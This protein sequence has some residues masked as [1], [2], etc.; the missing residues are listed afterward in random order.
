MNLLKQIFRSYISG[1]EKFYDFTGRAT[2]LEFWSFALINIIITSI[3]LPSYHIV[4]LIISLL[5]YPL[6]M[7]GLAGAGVLCYVIV[8]VNAF[9]DPDYSTHM[10]SLIYVATYI[11]LVPF[12]AL[13]IRRF[14]DAGCTP[15]GIAA[16]AGFVIGMYYPQSHL[17]SFCLLLLLILTLLPNKKH[18]GMWAKFATKSF[19]TNTQDIALDAANKND[20]VKPEKDISKGENK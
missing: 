20:I 2:R 4:F 12:L 17:I 7:L 6:Q 19:G 15:I 8:L 18:F 10:L 11:P 1:F 5:K 3:F 9:A 13:F 16:L 14:N